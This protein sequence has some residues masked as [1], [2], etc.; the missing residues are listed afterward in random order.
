[1]TAAPAPGTTPKPG[2]TPV[3]GSTPKPGSTP[4][5]GPT[6][7]P[8]S[9]P[10]PGPTPTPTPAPTPVPTP[11]GA[12]TYYLYN[13]PSP[14]VG[15]TVSHSVL[16]LGTTPPTATELF[17]YDLNRNSMPGV[18]IAKGG[19][20]AGETN[21]AKYQLWEGPQL[22]A[23]LLLQGSAVLHIWSATKDFAP[24]KSGSVTAYLRSCSGAVCTTIAQ[25]TVNDDTWQGPGE[26]WKQT[27]FT[28]SNL[29]YTAAAGMK[30]ELKLIVDDS[31]EDDIMFAYDTATY[32]ARLLF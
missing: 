5:P 21:A 15:D 24:D 4:V 8:G 1:V 32:K 11:T 23:P 26:T 9:T 29:N 19:S 12:L 13:F 25:A 6:P 31:S 17:N 16:P 28:F 20:G 7:T 27:T 3:P 22:G 14:P 18:T 30:L 2:S 10:P